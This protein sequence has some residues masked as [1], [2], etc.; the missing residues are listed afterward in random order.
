MDVMESR[1]ELADAARAKD[2]AR[3]VK[4]GEGMRAREAETI[5]R[6][7]RQFAEA[8]ADAQKV[9]AILPIVGELRY[10]RRFLD[11]VSALEEELAP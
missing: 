3:I 5:A 7:G 4:L 8:G 2:L 9:A 6:L 11:E 10:F 1:E